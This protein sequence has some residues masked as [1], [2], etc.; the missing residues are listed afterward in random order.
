MGIFFNRKNKN[1]NNEV[2]LTDAG[3]KTIGQ[4]MADWYMTSPDYIK[5]YAISYY[6]EYMYVKIYYI[7]MTV[8]Q[9]NDLF[10]EISELET[11]WTF[12]GVQEYYENHEM[13]FVFRKR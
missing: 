8:P 2:T 6:K 12:L 1:K 3:A 9:K 4:V 10:I 11:D 5:S 13:C 7:E